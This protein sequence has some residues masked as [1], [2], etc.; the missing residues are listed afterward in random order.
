MGLDCK[1]LNPFDTIVVQYRMNDKMVYEI[2]SNSVLLKIQRLIAGTEFAGHTFVAGGFVRDFVMGRPS[3]DIDIVV[4]LP[5][6]GIS[7]AEFVRDKLGAIDVHNFERFGTAQV[8][9]D[10]MDIEFVMARR[11]SYEIGSRNPEVD[12]ATI[13]EDV[14]RRDFTIN[15]LLIDMSTGKILDLTGRGFR[16]IES[17]IIRTTQNPD[18]IFEEDPLRMLRAVRFSSQLGFYLKMETVYGIAHNVKMI[19]TISKERIR[20]EFMKLLQGKDYEFALR[21]LIATGLAGYI[22]PEMKSMV[23]LNGG[24]HHIKNVFDHTMDVVGRVPASDPVL[25]LAALLHDIGK[26]AVM[27]VGADDV[28]FHGHAE[29]SVDIAKAFMDEYKFSAEEIRDVVDF[30]GNHMRFLQPTPPSP[31]LVRRIIRE[32]GRE[33][34]DRFMLLVSADV[35]PNPNHPRPFD[36]VAEVMKIVHEDDKRE[37]PMKPPVTGYDVMEAFGLPQCGEIGRLLNV[38]N[39]YFLENPSATKEELI[40]VMKEAI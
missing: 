24:S 8:V 13:K 27:T 26:P 12:Y 33:R 23:G 10:G 17:G 4:D 15:T 18:V 22:L 39:E 36:T 7:L 19:E 6:G 21:K 40:A 3:K 31:K 30:V 9:L 2:A 25:R 14:M 5:N 29:A 37:V 11:E 32:L 38:A 34:F 16:D 20:D 28:H 35:K 1:K